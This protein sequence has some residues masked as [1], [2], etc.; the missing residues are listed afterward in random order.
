MTSISRRSGVRRATRGGRMP[1]I[2]TVRSSNG[3]SAIV[4]D[5]P[6]TPGSPLN[7]ARHRWSLMTASVPFDSPSPDRKVLPQAARTPR[8]SKRPVV[9]DVPTT[10]TGA[11][12]DRR[13][14]R[15]PPSQAARSRKPDVDRVRSWYSSI[16]VDGIRDASTS[17]VQ[18]TDTSL[19]GSANG[20]R[21]NHTAFAIDQ[22]AVATAVALA[23]T[24][25]SQAPSSRCRRQKLTA[26]RM[27]ASAGD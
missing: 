9:T 16:E 20:R 27:D 1:T 26:C 23:M 24:S 4:T 17:E 3:P 25:T 8:T 14:Q 19:A 21:S 7:A 15:P 22:T 10:S 18:P 11:F 12:S 2:W 13:N 6:T 5:R